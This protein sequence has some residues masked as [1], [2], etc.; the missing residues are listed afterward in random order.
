MKFKDFIALYD[1]ETAEKML[2]SIEGVEKVQEIS[3]DAKPLLVGLMD[4]NVSNLW[5]ED[6][7][8][9]VS[10]EYFARPF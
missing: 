9:G 2:L 3:L 8:L 10:L 5:I 7:L 6:G 4:M 1:H